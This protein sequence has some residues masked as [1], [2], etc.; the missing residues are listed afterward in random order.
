MVIDKGIGLNRKEVKRLTK[1]IKNIDDGRKFP[2]TKHYIGLGLLM[3]KLIVQ[4]FN[5]V[6]KF[7]TKINQGSTFYFTF[8]LEKFNVDSHLF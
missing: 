1:L 7:N 5:G 2:F 6:L 8:D 3:S 4:K